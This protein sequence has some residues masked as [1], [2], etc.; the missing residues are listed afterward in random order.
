M[1]QII[2]SVDVDSVQ[3]VRVRDRSGIAPNQGGWGR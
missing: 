2:V 1:I 3:V